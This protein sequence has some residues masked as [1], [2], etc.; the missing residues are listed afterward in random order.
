M[1]EFEVRICI[2]GS[3]GVAIYI[4]APIVKKLKL[5][6]E[7]NTKLQATLDEDGDIII[8]SSTLVGE[9]DDN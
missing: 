2:S 1:D 4:P 5:K 6:N 8:Y 3:S 7:I 9:E